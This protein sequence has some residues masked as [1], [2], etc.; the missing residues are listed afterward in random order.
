MRR[1]AVLSTMFGRDSGQRA[2]CLRGAALIQ[3]RQ[4]AEGGEA[5]EVVPMEHQLPAQREQVTFVST[6]PRFLVQDLGGSRS[7]SCPAPQHLYEVFAYLSRLPS[8]ALTFLLTLTV[9]AMLRTAPSITPSSPWTVSLTPIPG[10][11]PSL[12]GR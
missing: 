9:V 6:S 7:A 4:T 8:H 11:N 3:N 12:H 2:P 5:M 1:H 10:L